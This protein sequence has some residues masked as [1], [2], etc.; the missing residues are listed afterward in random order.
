M[1]SPKMFHL[2]LTTILMLTCA[3]NL[4]LLAPAGQ[5]PPSTP[6]PG[7][8]P[9]TNPPANA[10]TATDTALPA[11]ATLPP[12][13]PTLAPTAT[14]TV[15]QV[16]PIS[17]A[18]N[19]RSGPGMQYAVDDTLNV[20]QIAQIQGRSSDGFWWYISDPNN[21]GSF[22][23]VGTAVVTASGNLTGIA[24]V[25]PPT[26]VVTS[27]T[28][29]VSAP[30]PPDCSGPGSANFSGTITTNG[31]TKVKF[32]WEIGGDASNTTPSQTLNFS[33]AGTKSAPNPGTY[34]KGCGHYTITL[35]VTSPND[36]SAT[37][38]FSIEP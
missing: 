2:L 29:S 17:A 35:H 16:T 31:A 24:I 21:P 15:P 32:Q 28:V 14:P 10:P 8:V 13:P 20:G 37:K 5:T 36:I 9:Q 38:K 33:A 7:N 3:C 22:C 11:A 19:C 4:P 27:V 23:W 1:K 34:Q 30:K 12:I 18:V 6:P 25:Q 26:A